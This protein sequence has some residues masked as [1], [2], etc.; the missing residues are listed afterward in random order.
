MYADVTRP[1]RCLTSKSVRFE[2][3]K[4]CQKSFQEL[5][6]LL[7]RVYVDESPVGVVPLWHSNMLLVMKVGRKERYGIQWIT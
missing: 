2:W 5:K 1:L 4:E 7:A 3:T 6:D